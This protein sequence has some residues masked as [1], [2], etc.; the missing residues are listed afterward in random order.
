MYYIVFDLEF[1]QD[2]TAFQTTTEKLSSYPFEIIQFG[3]VKLDLNLQTVAT[4]E[5]NVQPNIYQNLNPFIS[6]LT[7]ITIDQLLHEK[8]FVDVFEDFLNFIGASDPVFCVW[9]MS[10][11]KELYKNATY[12]KLGLKKIPT[13]YINIQ[14][15][16]SSYLGLPVTRLLNLQIAVEALHIPKP[17]PFHN[18]LHDAY[19]TAEILKKLHSPFIIPQHYDPNYQKVRPRQPKKQIDYDS[20]IRQFEKMY[21]RRLTQEEIDMI[22]LAYKMGKTNQ[23]VR[24]E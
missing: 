14:P 23:F 2:L 19:Y 17:Y 5:R 3:A 6:E 8:P 20:L 21:Q 12:Y 24:Y 13:K 9:G 16:V 15:Y 10:D 11:M 18:A 7:G 4:F 22:K 1:N